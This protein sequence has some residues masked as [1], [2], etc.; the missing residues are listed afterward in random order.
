MGHG[1]AKVELEKGQDPEL[2]TLAQQIIDAQQREIV[3]M[4]EQLGNRS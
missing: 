4:R 2:R 3:A 1:M